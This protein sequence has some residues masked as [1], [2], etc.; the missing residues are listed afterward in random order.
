MRYIL[1][2]FLLFINYYAQISFASSCDRFLN[3]SLTLSPMETVEIRRTDLSSFFLFARIN[4]KDFSQ[5]RVDQFTISPDGRWIAAT[6]K[7]DEGFLLLSH[8]NLTQ[9]KIQ[10]NFAIKL[11][12]QQ[13]AIDIRVVTNPGRLYTIIKEPDQKYQDE[14]YNLIV[15]NLKKPQD[16]PVTIFHQSQVIQML[17]IDNPSSM[18]RIYLARLRGATHTIAAFKLDLQTG[19]LE[20]L[21]YSMLSFHQMSKLMALSKI[22]TPTWYVSQLNAQRLQ[23]KGADQE[24]NFDFNTH[25][26]ES[27]SQWLSFTNRAAPWIE[28]LPKTIQNPNHL[29]FKDHLN[30]QITKIE[31][32]TFYQPQLENVIPLNHNTYLIQ[33]KAREPINR[34]ISKWVTF[35]YIKW[36]DEKEPQ[37]LSEAQVWMR[38]VLYPNTFFGLQISDSGEGELFSI[39]H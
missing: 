23:I 26:V 6:R 2:F 5:N 20:S 17:V 35:T 13:Q 18:S 30:D 3:S 15:H 28:Y 31:F 8:L 38:Q 29:A 36:P 14:Q 27:K 33:A 21:G 16:P 7:G 39:S 34:A 10:D 19:A 37:L 25:K 1:G 4:L 12:E 24:F 22:E 11:K 9:N 32:P